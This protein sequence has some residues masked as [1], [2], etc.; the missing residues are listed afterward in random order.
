MDERP[1]PSTIVDV[2]KAAGVSVATVSRALRG[3]DRVSPVTREKVRRVAEEMHYVASPTATSLASG[4]TRIVGVIVPF[5]SRWYFASMLSAIGKS[6]REQG[7]QVLLF[8]LESEE[9]NSRLSLTRSMLWKRV[10]GVISITVPMT[11]AELELLSGLHVPVVSV[12]YPL[13]GRSSVGIDDAAAA[14]T[15]VAHVLELG[16]RDIAYVGAVTDMAALVETPRTRLAAALETMATHGVQPREEWVLR[17][18]WTAENAR[19]RARDLFAATPTPTAV[20]CGSDEIAFGVHMAARE[21]DLRIPGD[22]SIV[23]IDDHPLAGLFDLTTVRQDLV[24]QAG[25]A[26][27]LLLEELTAE[28]ARRLE[29]RHLVHDTE[30]VQR[31]STAPPI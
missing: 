14:R 3:L 1:G 29:H 26:V 13:D 16:H 30:L 9:F 5:V 11:A 6:L 7:Y 2:A 12:G 24:G 18:D 15:A 31:R 25:Q 8:D 21:R 10:D 4:R 17:T 22:V 23:G 27:S 28:K 20:V 19:D